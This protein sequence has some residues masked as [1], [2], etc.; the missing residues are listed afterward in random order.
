MEVSHKDS[1]YL[2]VASLED[3]NWHVV[4]IHHDEIIILSEGASE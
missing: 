4:S 1:D 2:A 3:G